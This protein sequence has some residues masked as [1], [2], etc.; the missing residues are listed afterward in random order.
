MT[1]M[2]LAGISAIVVAA[3]AIGQQATTPAA[4]NTER[5]ASVASATGKPGENEIKARWAA[6][7]TGRVEPKDGEIRL[8]S[9]MPGKVADVAVK[10]NMSATRPSEGSAP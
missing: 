10:I 7:A 3:L 4:S 2:M 5:A 9:Q 6:S 8:L 1:A